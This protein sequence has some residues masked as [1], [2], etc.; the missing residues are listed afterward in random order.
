MS[1]SL[2][3]VLDAPGGADVGGYRAEFIDLVRR[4]Q[5]LGAR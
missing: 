3:A 2:S 5:S 4:A 1:N